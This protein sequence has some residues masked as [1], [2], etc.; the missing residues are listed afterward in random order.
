LKKK[1]K[2]FWK[3]LAITTDSCLTNTRIGRAAVG[4]KA[5]NFRNAKNKSC[6]L[7]EFLLYFPALPLPEFQVATPAF[8]VLCVLDL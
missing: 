3:V 5:E 6:I 8:M 4:Q 1:L 2:I 7:P